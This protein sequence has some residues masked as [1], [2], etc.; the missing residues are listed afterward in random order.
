MGKKSRRT[1]GGAAADVSRKERLQERRQRTLDAAAN[2]N[3]HQQHDDASERQCRR[4]F[5]GD[6]VWFGYHLSDGENPYTYRGIVHRVSEHSLG[7]VS[8][9]SKLDGSNEV[10]DV[11]IESVFPDFKDVTLRFNVG[12]PVVCMTNRGWVPHTVSHQWAIYETPSFS[13]IQGPEDSVPHYKCRNMSNNGG[14]TH[15][16]A[17]SD[18]DY[19]L[20][21]HPTTFR[22]SLGRSVV[23]NPSLAIGLRKLEKELNAS[24]CWVQGTVLQTDVTGRHDCYCVYECSFGS[25]GKSKC[26]ITQD[27]DEHIAMVKFDPRE[28]LLEAISQDCTPHHLSYLAES[29][30]I[31]VST[32]RDMVVDKAIKYGSYNTFIWLQESYSFDIHTVLDASGNN[33]LHQIAKSDRICNNQQSMLNATNLAGK[34]WLEILVE[35]GDA[36]SLDLALS[37]NRAL[38]WTLSRW[39]YDSCKLLKESVKEKNDFIIQ[40]I[41]DG[42]E[43][44]RNILHREKKLC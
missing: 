3:N 23:F 7:I 41:F 31:D 18:S 9:Q 14:Y 34:I 1:K 44:N 42:Y 2:L 28:R 16:A 27:D 40:T 8:L 37:F 22:F 19:H 43:R 29:Y 15:V 6:R 32:F 38:S 17:P 36:R 33:L 35:R 21:K 30:S 26:F 10:W 4:Y 13:D 11:D 24:D 39:D 25:K 5:V 12:D 20:I